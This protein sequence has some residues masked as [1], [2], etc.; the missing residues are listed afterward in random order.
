MLIASSELG[1]V[2]KYV[3]A[4]SVPSYLQSMFYNFDINEHHF[5]STTFNHNKCNLHVNN[6]VYVHF[7][8]FRVHVDSK[9]DE[10]DVYVDFYIHFG[11]KYD[12]FDVYVNFD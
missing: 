6:D 1:Y 9:Y 3:V 7:D 5:H 4:Q 8:D 2:R 12:K 11:S 10:F